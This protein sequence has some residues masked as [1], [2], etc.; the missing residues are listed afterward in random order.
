MSHRAK[1]NAE[2]EVSVLRTIGK[3]LAVQLSAF[4]ARNELFE[5]YGDRPVQPPLDKDA[6]SEGL[7][8]PEVDSGKPAPELLGAAAI[9]RVVAEGPAVVHHWATW[10]EACSAE[11]SLLDT[12]A[13]RADARMVALSWDGF[14]GADDQTAIAQVTEAQD[15]FGAGW[16]HIVVKGKPPHFFRTLGVSH[17]QIPQTWLV[18][19]NGE[20]LHRIEGPMTQADVDDLIARASKL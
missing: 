2:G 8:A 9:K 3:R 10:C 19:Q 6:W 1:R 17:K 5:R 20:V 13:A 7:E 14:E 4:V 11:V 18:G 12:L 16:K 15:D